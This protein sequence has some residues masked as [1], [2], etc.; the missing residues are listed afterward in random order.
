MIKLLKLVLILLAIT[1]F[2]PS[3]A[4]DI[5]MISLLTEMTERESLA[6]YP[7]PEFRTKQFSSYDRKA[8]EP[9]GNNWYANHDHTHFLRGE[10]TENGTE[11]VMFEADQPGAI[12]R[13]WMTFGG[14]VEGAGDGMIRIYIDGN[15]EPVIEERAI[16]I[17]D[18]GDAIGPPLHSSVSELTLLKRRGHNLYLPIPYGERCKITYQSDK[19]TTNE[20]GEITDPQ[21]AIYYVINYREYSGDTKVKSFDRNTHKTYAAEVNRA[22]RLLSYP[23]RALFSKQPQ[24]SVQLR[25]LSPGESMEL[26]IHGGKYIKALRMKLDADSLPRALRSTVI[27]FSFD[28][29]TTLTVPVGDFF[30]TGYEI[31][32][33]ETYYTKVYKD[34]LMAC[35]WPMPFQTGATIRIIN[36]GIQRVTIEGMDV[37]TDSW[38]WNDRSMYFGGSWKQFYSKQTGGPRNPEDLTFNVLEGK[39][40]YAGDL[41]TLYNN[42]AAWWG[43]GDEKIYIDGETFPSHFGTGTEDYYGYAW[44]RPEPF[45]H[46]FI[47]QPDGSGNQEEGT[48]VNIRFR[49]LD[50]IPFTKSLKMNMELWHWKQTT[51]NYAPATFFYL[52]P[53]STSKTE[54][55]I[56]EANQPLAFRKK[57]ENIPVMKDGII[58]GE[59][60]EPVRIDA[61]VL[62]HQSGK[63]WDENAHLWWRSADKGDVLSLQFT[64]E[65]SYSGRDIE[66]QLTKAIDYGIVSLSINNGPEL[67][68]DGYGVGVSVERVIVENAMIRQGVNTLEIKIK[69][70]NEQARDGNMFGIDYLVIK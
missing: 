70:R 17:M 7:F 54:F 15:E 53:G 36:T 39:G 8:I 27:S 20:K 63:Q 25:K 61:G 29:C 3:K 41:I 14:F 37:F 33:Y 22:Q 4:Q 31:N 52:R 10:I 26:D 42:A 5:S 34:G 18:I 56:S 49:A 45:S 43:E 44:A 62:A 59:K 65:M 9:G 64:S 28:D 6:I 38:E 67:V 23:F 51:V 13:W 35:A 47:A 30:G 55:S 60:M 46:P 19:I 24:A 69:G 66:L 32:P 21:I 68:F 40:V 2:F 48:T 11:W 57:A 50:K 12:V 16:D 58:Q 1:A